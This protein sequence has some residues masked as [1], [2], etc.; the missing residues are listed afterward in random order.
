MNGAKLRARLAAGEAISMFTPHHTSSGL[1]ARL[2]ELGADAVFLDCEHGTWSF[3]DVRATGQ[4]VRSAGGAAIVRPHSHERPIIIR[5][6]N[7]GADGIMVPMV[8]N[9]DEARSIVDA[10]RY[11]LPSDYEKR[12]V[13]A[14]IETVGAIDTLEEML[15]VEGIDVFFI[16]PGDLSQDMGYPPAPPFGEPRPDVVMDKVTVAVKKIRAAGKIAG[17]LATLEEI[18]HW[19]ARGVQFFYVH[20]D[21]F[22]RR[23]ISAVKNALA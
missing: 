8:A 22:L 21:P 6:L 19:R 17:T 11:A 23:G 1:S 15:T 5:Y 9:A 10:V 18:P 12:L 20:S 16:G 4:V 13:I 2:V 14:M 3:E 7:A